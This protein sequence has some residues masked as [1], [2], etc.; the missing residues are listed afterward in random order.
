M[1]RVSA[2]YPAGP[3]TR[4][5]LDYYLNKHTPMAQANKGGPG[6]DHH[7]KGFSMFL[8]GGGVKRGTTYGATDDLGYASVENVVHVHDLQATLLHQLGLDHRRVIF[9][10]HGR[11]Q[12][13]VHGVSTRAYN[14]AYEG[15]AGIPALKDC[16][17]T[18]ILELP[19]AKIVP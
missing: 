15:N 9:P 12:L 16:G 5:D 18:G 10:H 7:M 11:T 1:I 2:M 4:F 3:D 17:A 19:I 13:I 6:R 8:C 14:H